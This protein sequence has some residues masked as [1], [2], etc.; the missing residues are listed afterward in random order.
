MGSSKSGYLLAEVVGIKRLGPVKKEG[1][2]ESGSATH[3]TYCGLS[4]CR[5]VFIGVKS[6]HLPAVYT[7]TCW[8]CGCEGG[9]GDWGGGGESDAR[10]ESDRGN[11]YHR[12][13]GKGEKTGGGGLNIV[14][15]GGRGVG[16]LTLQAAGAGGGRGGGCGGGGEQKGGVGGGRGVSTH[17]KGGFHICKR[18]LLAVRPHN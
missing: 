6:H 1:G 15:W 8:A 10:W 5:L 13:L 9:V 18:P 16:R 12:Q 2:G 17:H 4:T 14:S 3:T 7:K 11:T